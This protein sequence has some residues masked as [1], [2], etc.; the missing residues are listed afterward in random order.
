M[1]SKLILTA[2][3]AI[4]TLSP[5][6]LAGDIKYPPINP[7]LT[8]WQSAAEMPEMKGEK[9]D[10]LRDMTSG[11]KPFDAVKSK[12]IVSESETALKLFARAANSPAPCDWGLPLE[13]G[14]EMALPHVSKMM[15]LSRLAILKA[16][17]LF[18]EGRNS[19]G[20]QWLLAVHRAARHA[21]AGDLLISALVQFAID[22]S[23]ARAGALHCLGWDEATRKIY[24]DGLKAL[25]PLHSLQDAVR[26]EVIFVD[27]VEHRLLSTDPKLRRKL[28]NIL[29]DANQS[30][31]PKSELEAD[32]KRMEEEFNPENG[33]KH[34]AEIRDFYRRAQVALGK[35]WKESQ[36]ELQALAKEAQGG[37]ILMKL[38]FPAFEGLNAKGFEIATLRTMLDA[39]LQYGPKL[40]AAAAAN[41][42]DAFEVEPLELK[43]A[44]D[45]S[46][47][48]KAAKQYAK[49]GK[50]IELKLGK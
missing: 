20:I 11:K 14:P 24:A 13:D 30:H 15:Q 16:D 42:K 43:K 45:G 10:L 21:G 17:S 31:E 33:P 25:P 23:A 8:Y 26:G 38:T 18:A 28:Q 7:A 32:A 2:A 3:I 41:Y 27:W 40:D 5:C 48:L 49:P 44:E 39:A 4:L 29:V 1:K 47:I 22:T 34:V 37:N 36:T 19:E 50:E 9:A 6:I 12:E 35:P 46:L